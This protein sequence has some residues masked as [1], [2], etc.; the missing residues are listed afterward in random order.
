MTV[1]AGSL[2]IAEKTIAEDKIV[3]GEMILRLRMRGLGN[4]EILSALEK[5]PR[6]LFLRAEDHKVAYRDMWLPIE[7]G[8]TIHAPSTVAQMIDALSISEEH[9]VLEV[10]TGSGYQAA[11]LAQVAKSVFSIERYRTLIELAEQRLKTLK[12]ENVHVRLGDGLL[13][14][15]EKA[16]FDRIII[17]GS[18]PFIPTHLLDQVKFGGVMVAAVGEQGGVQELRRIERTGSRFI[19]DKIAN[20]RFVH[21]Q[22]GIAEIM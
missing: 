10:G 19:E 18:V 11:I 6:R 4:R 8:Q 16:P 17:S 9:R 14:F 2:S 22:G 7:C 21:M 1:M 5:T 13:G 20:V 12:I 15:P 3:L